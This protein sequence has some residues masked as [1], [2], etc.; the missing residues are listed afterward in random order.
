MLIHRDLSTKRMAGINPSLRDAVLKASESVDFFVGDH[1]GLRTPEEQADL[2]R[3]GVSWTL[4][5][6]HLTGDAVDLVAYDAEFKTPVWHLGAYERI[7]DA[8]FAACPVRL[9]WGGS[10]KQADLGHFEVADVR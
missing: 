8:M 9:V 2:V 7:R 1:G 4:R 10:W 6:K 5:S 3:R